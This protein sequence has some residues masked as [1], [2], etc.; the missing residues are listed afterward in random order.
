MTVQKNPVVLGRKLCTAKHHEG[1]R[2]IHVSFFEAR[3]RDS[4]GAVVALQSHCRTCNRI[5]QR[6]SKGIR[7]R[8]KPYA[9]RAPA[10]PREE[11][12]RRRRE[13]HRDAMND[14]DYVERRR[15]YARIYTE[16]KRREAGVEP[17]EFRNRKAPGRYERLVAAPMS[18]WVRRNLPRYQGEPSR[19]AA[20]CDVDEATIRRLRDQKVDVIS[21]DLADRILTRDGST[22][23]WEVYPHLYA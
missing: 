8:G 1:R 7:R 6:I 21:E 2:F 10:L 5:N 19:M 22:D 9:K 15:E 4:S 16:G 12:N 13:K 20:K 18:E 11:I 14:P 17:R 23:L 3:E